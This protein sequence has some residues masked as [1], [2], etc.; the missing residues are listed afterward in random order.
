MSKNP[1]G[2]PTKYNPKLQAEAD[3]YLFRLKELGHVVPSRVGLCCYLGIDKT[4]SYE[5]EKIY[6]EF[7]N[8]LRAVDTMQEHLAL[9]G[10]M[11]GDFNSTIVKLVLANHGYSDKQAIDHQSTDGTMTPKIIER[12]VVD[13]SANGG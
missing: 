6:P 2:R 4:T 1:V 11:I 9:N 13:P 5:W 10:G 3:Q 12:R 8:T 7:S